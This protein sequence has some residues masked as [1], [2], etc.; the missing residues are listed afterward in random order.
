MTTRSTIALPADLIDHPDQA[1]LGRH[2]R[3]A[4]GIRAPL[5]DYREDPDQLQMT[6]A[7]PGHRTV[8]TV[9]RAQRMADVEAETRGLLGKLDDLHKG[10]DSGPAWFW[11][12]DLTAALLTLSALTG[13]VTLLS[14]R[15]RR[16]SGFIM[17]ALGVASIVAIYLIWVPR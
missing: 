16:R 12:I 15:R 14:L 2:L 9:D 7:A 8:V 10:F 6:F 13:M 5:T 17:A 3:T 11:I 1:A 4:L